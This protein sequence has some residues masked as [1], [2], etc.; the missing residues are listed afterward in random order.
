ME[1]V[2]R[3][4]AINIYRKDAIGNFCYD[5]V[6]VYEKAGYTVY[7]YADGYDQNSPV[8]K[9]ALLF[10]ETNNQDIIFY[11]HSIYDANIECVVALPAKK[12]A[13]FHGITPP[14]YLK[15]YQ[16]ITAQQCEEGLQ[17]LHWLNKFDVLC[18]NSLSTLHQMK[19]YITPSL[20]P[21]VI[22]PIVASRDTLQ[23]I[24]K[25]HQTATQGKM[26]LLSVGR[27]VPHKK[28]EDIIQLLAAFTRSFPA[29]DIELT[30]IG[31][32]PE[33]EYHTDIL[34]LVSQL[35][36]AEKI[37]FKGFI[38]NEELME[39]YATAQCY[40]MMSEHEGFGVPLLEALKAQVPVLAYKKN[41]IGEV[42]GNAGSQFVTKDF[43][44]LA[45]RLHQILFD[46]AYR[47][48]IILGQCEQLK[49]L[50]AA[51]DDPIFLQLI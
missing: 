26:T 45:N 40:V 25:T 18:V 10:S 29:V 13:Y 8:K 23:N 33:N 49:K 9:Y 35:N 4:V 11:H 51:C 38:T 48:K 34:A 42:L 46:D 19:Q 21:Q 37:N 32:F 7:L 27:V 17:Q 47:Q 16:P 31:A 5:L 39:A 41:S 12:I 15:K 20:I 2:I 30:V 24:K 28:V 44:Q 22:P 36:I 14:E 43:N 50:M 6:N 1:R 3:I